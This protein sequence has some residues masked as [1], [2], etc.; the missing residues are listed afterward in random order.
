ME[1]GFG[2]CA[3]YY[4]RDDNLASSSSCCSSAAV[5]E[6]H[7]TELVLKTIQP[8]SSIKKKMEERVD[9]CNIHI[10]LRQK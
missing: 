5:N 8:F 3:D 6:N 9:I 4:I 1:S 7:E 2:E 10:A